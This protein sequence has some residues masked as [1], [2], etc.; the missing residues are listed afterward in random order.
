M[1]DPKKIEDALNLVAKE[2][3]TKFRKPTD[4]ERI[5]AAEVLYLREY[6]DELQRKLEGSVP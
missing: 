2:E 4:A 5:L 6:C 1:R 3:W